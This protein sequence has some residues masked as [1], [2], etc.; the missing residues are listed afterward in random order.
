MGTFLVILATM[1]YNTTPP[2]NAASIG[3]MWGRLLM[4]VYMKETTMMQEGA[5]GGGGGG[6]GMKRMSISSA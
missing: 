1:M 4:N 2:A 6:V 5:G 3:G